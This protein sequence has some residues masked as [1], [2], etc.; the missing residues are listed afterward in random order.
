LAQKIEPKKIIFGETMDSSDIQSEISVQSKLVDA[1][2]I[3]Q[4]LV[5]E[6]DRHIKDKEQ[7]LNDRLVHLRTNVIVKHFLPPTKIGLL[8]TKVDEKVWSSLRFVKAWPGQ[9]GTYEEISFDKSP[10]G[11]AFFYTIGEVAYELGVVED[12]GGSDAYVRITDDK[13]ETFKV[14]GA[15]VEIKLRAFQH[16]KELLVEINDRAENLAT[17]LD[18]YAKT[19]LRSRLK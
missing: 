12:F 3:D 18:E 10:K 19:Y 13:R 7:Q 5:T 1:I 8:A 4:S 11:F 16:L 14:T 2:A 17:K 15:P 9:C 6:I